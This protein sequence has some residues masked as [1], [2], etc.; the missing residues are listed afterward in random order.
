MVAARVPAPLAAFLVTDEW[1]GL[2]PRL[3]LH[4]GLEIGVVLSGAQERHWQGHV[5]SFGPGDVWL[6]NV[7]EPHAWRFTHPGLV[8][9][10][11]FAPEFLGPDLPGERPWLTPFSVPPAL[12][13]QVTTA[14]MRREVLTIGEEFRSEI[15]ARGRGWVS[16]VKI[17][18]MRLVLALT[19]EWTPPEGFADASQGL[20]RDLKRVLPA[21]EALRA[22]PEARLTPAE[23]A[24][25]CGLSVTQ[26][27]RVFRSS[28]GTSFS[29]FALRSRVSAAAKQL[30]ATDLT[31][32]D[33]AERTGF[34]DHSHLH[35]M[36]VRYYHCTPRHYR[37]LRGV[38]P[39]G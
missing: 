12:R 6:G 25:T 35:R 28:M 13:P 10:L 18:V 32:E 9:A 11:D 14:A 36:F 23:A 38:T 5:A 7:L 29:E 31:L 30:L 15:E 39:P 3:D 4:D 37:V 16:A 8:A 34:S 20:P 1:G 19:R 27:N 33:I 21:L 24:L 17:G 26:F 22:R 2:E